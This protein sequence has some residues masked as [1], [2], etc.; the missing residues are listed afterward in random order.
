[1]KRDYKTLI[2]NCNFSS[3]ANQTTDNTAPS[4]VQGNNFPGNYMHGFVPQELPSYSVFVGDG[5]FNEASNNIS[6]HR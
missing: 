4:V 2:P 5:D 6:N 1:M 3:G